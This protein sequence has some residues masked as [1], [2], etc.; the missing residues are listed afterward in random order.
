M[1]TRMALA[2]LGQRHPCTH[3]IPRCYCILDIRVPRCDSA[4]RV[5]PNA[6]AHRA[7]PCVAVLLDVARPGCFPA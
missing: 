5:S 3:I 1:G 2:D 6:A 7:V 4:P